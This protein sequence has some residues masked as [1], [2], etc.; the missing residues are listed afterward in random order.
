MKNE[1]FNF[2]T[3]PL[4]NKENTRYKLKSEQFLHM[5]IIQN[6]VPV[7]KVMGPGNTNPK[8]KDF[9]AFICQ[10][11]FDDKKSNNRIA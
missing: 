5:L 9:I 3:W 11:L 10:I 7:T 6:A 1:Q 8:T 4:P 2:V